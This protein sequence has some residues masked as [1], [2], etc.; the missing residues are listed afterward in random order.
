MKR[1][2]LVINFKS[3]PL[4]YNVSMC[5]YLLL[6]MFCLNKLLNIKIKSK[7]CLGNKS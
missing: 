3:I 7:L 2:T 6:Y 1:K 4:S 5:Y